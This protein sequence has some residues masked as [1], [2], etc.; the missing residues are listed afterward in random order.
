MKPYIN[1]TV[2]SYSPFCYLFIRLHIDCDICHNRCINS[3]KTE[4][5]CAH[6]LRLSKVLAKINQNLSIKIVFLSYLRIS[7]SIK[8]L[9]SIYPACPVFSL[10]SNQN[11]LSSLRSRSRSSTNCS[12]MIILQRANCLSISVSQ[13]KLCFGNST[14]LY[15]KPCVS[16]IITLCKNPDCFDTFL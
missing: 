14:V 3:Y 12:S 5:E 10:C 9:E 11:N 6:R 13:R 7:Q 8:L 2:L 16:P 15:H 1:S 4:I